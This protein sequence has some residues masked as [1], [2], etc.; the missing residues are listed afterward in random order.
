MTADDPESPEAG[1]DVGNEV[2][3]HEGSPTGF[4]LA[5]ISRVLVAMQQTTGPLPPAEWLEAAERH[6]PGVT[7]TL[8]QDYLAERENARELLRRTAAL[9]HA[10][11]EQFASYQR[12]Q[13]LAATTIVL[14]IA[15]GGIVLALAGKSLYGFALLV[16]EVAGLVLAFL[17]GRTRDGE[18]P[19]SE[20]GGEG[21]VR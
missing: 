10:S 7:E 21:S 1:E 14:V 20:E 4:D 15:A 5:G 2:D 16:F 11:F 9:D 19:P 12:S 8:V 18:Q 13:L 3:V 17:S 6:H